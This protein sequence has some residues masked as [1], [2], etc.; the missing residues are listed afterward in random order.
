M[1]EAELIPLG[2]STISSVKVIAVLWS[3]SRRAL[4]RAAMSNGDLPNFADD[5][6]RLGG[7]TYLNTISVTGRLIIKR[8]AHRKLRPALARTLPD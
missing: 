8:Y 3:K 6:L 7:K 2:I 5:F 4:V 1:N